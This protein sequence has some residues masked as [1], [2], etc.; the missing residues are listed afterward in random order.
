MTERQREL[1]QI[2][3]QQGPVALR[4][5]RERLSSP[6]SDRMIQEDLAHLRRLGLVESKGR[7]RGSA[8]HLRKADE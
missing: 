5:I 7:G 8:Y 1:L 4:E 3:A 2:L 6:P